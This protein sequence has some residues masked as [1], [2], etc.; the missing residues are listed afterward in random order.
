[1]LLTTQHFCDILLLQSK[2]KGVRDLKKNLYHEPY[3]KFKGFL[4]E[5]EITYKNVAELLGISTQSTCD[6]IN[7]KSDFF[8][9]ETDKI[10]SMWNVDKNFFYHASCEY[11]NSHMR[12]GEKNATSSEMGKSESA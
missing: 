10:C 6:K 9:S 1:M 3:R 8:V 5:N 12:H 2:R 7:G 11:N 4:R